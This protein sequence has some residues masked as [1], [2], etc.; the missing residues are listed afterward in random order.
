MKLRLEFILLLIIMLASGCDTGEPGKTN[1]IIV[2]NIRSAYPQIKAEIPAIMQIGHFYPRD[3]P[4]HRFLSSSFGPMIE[5]QT[6]GRVRV[7]V[8]P[9]SF[10]EDAETLDTALRAE[11]LEG[12]VTN[13]LD[14]DLKL[15]VSDG[16]LAEIAQNDREFIQNIT[17]SVNI[18][19]DLDKLDTEN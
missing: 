6:A 18:S 13:N 15:R 9:Q 10:L 3:H 2:G 7:E 17:N 1:P 16:F 4:I 12:I 11:T 19:G 5:K 8:F 14:G